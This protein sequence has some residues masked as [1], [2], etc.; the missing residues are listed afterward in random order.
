VASV[1]QWEHKGLYLMLSR[2]IKQNKTKQ[3][4]TKQNNRPGAEAQVYDP[5][6]VQK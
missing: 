2:K 6:T 3:N 4:K 5:I 1:F